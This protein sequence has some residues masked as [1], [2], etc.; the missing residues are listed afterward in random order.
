MMKT[1]AA[2]L[3][4]LLLSVSAQAQQG[5]DQM[6]P[7][8]ALTGTEKFPMCQGCSTG[9]VNA[10]TTT[11]NAIKTFVNTGAAGVGAINAYTGQ[12]FL[13]GGENVNQQWVTSE[14]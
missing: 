5:I 14:S 3:V 6:N 11:A 2:V 4:L 10:T 13:G 8:T 9:A 12:F 1:L 7:G